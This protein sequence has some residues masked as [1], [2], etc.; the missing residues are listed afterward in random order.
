MT[1]F[2]FRGVAGL[3][4]ARSVPAVREPDGELRKLWGAV[5]PCVAMDHQHTVGLLAFWRCTQVVDAEM[6]AGFTLASRRKVHRAQ[7][8]VS[9]LHRCLPAA[10]T[11]CF[12]FWCLCASPS[13]DLLVG[14]VSTS[15]PVPSRVCESPLESHCSNHFPV[16]PGIWMEVA[17]KLFRVPWLVFARG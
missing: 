15:N 6:G 2:G 5:V 10:R 1:Q 8:A 14:A 17:A 11:V 3:A 7:C 9:A 4:C 13:R 12:G 16:T